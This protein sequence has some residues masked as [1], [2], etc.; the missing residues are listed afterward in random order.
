MGCHCAA[1]KGVP[2]NRARP[3]APKA[4]NIPHGI[5]P[6]ESCIFCAEKHVA[7]A[8]TNATARG[9]HAGIRQLLIGELEC[10]RRHTIIAYQPVSTLITQT[11][12]ALASRETDEIV[13]I[14]LQR[15]TSEIQS[16]TTAIKD[17]R[18]VTGVPK[19]AQPTIVTQGASLHPLIGEIHFCAAWRLAFECGYTALNRYMIIGDLSEAQ[20]HFH[21]DFYDFSNLVRAMRHKVQRSEQHLIGADWTVLS[22]NLDVY[23]KQKFEHIKTKYGTDISWYFNHAPSV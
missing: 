13:L 19:V 9:I 4:N 7:A 6:G 12:L 5:L 18:D 3:G 2:P 23:I 20:V 1:N 21:P 16:I 17:G 15:A 10:A 22:Y 8:L 14:L 11:M